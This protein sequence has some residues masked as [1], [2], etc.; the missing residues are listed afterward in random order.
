M[1]LTQKQEWLVARYLRAFAEQLGELPHLD[2]E[3][4]VNQLRGRLAR[5]LDQLQ[6]PDDEAVLNH[7]RQ[8]GHPTQLA[9]DLLEHRPIERTFTLATHECVW[10]G[11][12]GGLSAY[13]GISSKQ[14][15]R[16]A[17]ACGILTGPLALIAYLTLYFAMYAR[18]KRNEKAKIPAVAP[19][20]LA[21]VLIGTI[22]ILVALNL[23]SSGMVFG[24]EQAYSFGVKKPLPNLGEWNWLQNWKDSLIFWAFFTLVPMAVFSA[25]P[26]A[27]DWD[28]TAKRLVQAG[29][30]IYAVILCAGLASFAVGAIVK[31]AQALSG[32]IAL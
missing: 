12:C 22:A 5:E 31:A 32:G 20:Q 29:I 3:K 6:T 21:R 25:L 26:A 27:N 28:A 30:C 11:V 7:L 4:A 17:V 14:I 23:A 18:S 15:R 9:K 13:L 10:L 16:L 19:L 2:R 8:I 24:M 1:K